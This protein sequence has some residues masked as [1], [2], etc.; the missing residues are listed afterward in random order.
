MRGNP[1]NHPTPIPSDT[2]HI[3]GRLLAAL[4]RTIAAAEE[5]RLAREELDRL[6]E[7]TQH[8]AESAEVTR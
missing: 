4:D 1:R 5:A 2:R 7:A 8:G 3:V 6:A